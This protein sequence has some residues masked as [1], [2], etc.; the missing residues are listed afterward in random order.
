MEIKKS[1]NKRSYIRGICLAGYLLSTLASIAGAIGFM[2]IM[3]DSMGSVFLC[4]L[5]CFAVAGYGC[6]FFWAIEN[7]FGTQD[8]PIT[9]ALHIIMMLISPLWFVLWVANT[10]DFFNR[11]ANMKPYVAAVQAILVLL[12][13]FY[14][15]YWFFA[16]GERCDQ[17]ERLSDPGATRKTV[18]YTVLAIFIPVIPAAIMQHKINNA[19]E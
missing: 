9:L 13:P 16:Q 15:I 7:A 18:M 19:I 4:G 2:Q 14:S 1:E 11:Y 5:L 10:T 6:L 8:K 3:G 17:V 12:I